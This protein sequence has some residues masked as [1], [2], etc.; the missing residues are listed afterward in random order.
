M[1]VLISLFLLLLT[2]NNA[3]AEW[4]LFDLFK[5]P[6]YDSQGNVVKA[7]NVAKYR[8]SLYGAIILYPDIS[9]LKILERY[10]TGKKL[11]IK[12]DFLD[13][14]NERKTHY[15]IINKIKKTPSEVYCVPLASREYGWKSFQAKVV[16]DEKAE[17]LKMDWGFMKPITEPVESGVTK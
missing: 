15:V 8:K 6:I 3:Q 5:T 11:L 1:A 9:G 17:N 13:I 7:K 10:D 12:V 2:A 14:H 16:T 4:V